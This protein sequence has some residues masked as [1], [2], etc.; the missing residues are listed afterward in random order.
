MRRL[1]PIGVSTYSR[2]EHL[3]RTIDALKKN[4]LA[5]ESELYVFS[6]APKPGDEAKVD[7]VRKYLAAIDGF[8]RVHV[9][10]RM[11]NGRVENC[12]GG[13]EELLNMHGRVIF[14][15]DDVIAGPGFLQ[16]MNDALD[17]YEDDPRVGSISAYCPPIRIPE[18]YR[19]DVFALTRFNPWGVGLWRRYYKM[20]TPIAPKEYS[21]IVSDKKSIKRMARSLGEEGLEMIRMDFEGKLDAGDMKSMFWQFCDK[22][23]TVYPRKSLTCSIGQDGSGYHMGITDKWNVREVWA[24]VEGFQFVPRIGINEKIERSHFDFYRRNTLREKVI[25]LL[26][27]IGVDRYLRPIYRRGKAY[28]AHSVWRKTASAKARQVHEERQ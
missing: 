28:I 2:L 25:R 16:F 4:T 12:R 23:L 17:F 8:K 24:K 20:N 10:E 5:L 1:A 18:G 6:D 26:T 3:R 7:T 11:T 13:I 19:Y 27:R 22:K 15:E 9:L 21:E 14:L